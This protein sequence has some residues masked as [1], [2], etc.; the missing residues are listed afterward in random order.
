MTKHAR[1]VRQMEVVALR[2]LI[3]LSLPLLSA[4]MVLEGVE[5]VPSL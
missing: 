3:I 5:Q 1:K 4:L 2:V